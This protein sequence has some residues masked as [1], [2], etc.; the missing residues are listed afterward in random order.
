M[1]SAKPHKKWQQVMYKGQRKLGAQAELQESETVE[2]EMCHMLRSV[3]FIGAEIP[4]Q[5]AARGLAWQLLLQS[6]GAI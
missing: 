4:K 2:S 5:E 3:L 1:V 6:S